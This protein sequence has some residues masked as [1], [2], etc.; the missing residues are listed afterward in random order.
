LAKIL[1]EENQKIL[2]NPVKR[3]ETGVK[4]RGWD[5]RS[6]KERIMIIKKVIKSQGPFSTYGKKYILRNVE[7]LLGCR[8]LGDIEQIYGEYWPE[9]VKFLEEKQAVELLKQI[10]KQKTG[11]IKNG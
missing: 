10:H 9:V 8:P 3:T 1:E 4:H 11:G 5:D 7:F 2:P 6:E